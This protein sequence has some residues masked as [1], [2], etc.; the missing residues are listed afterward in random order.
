MRQDDAVQASALKLV[1]Y[2]THILASIGILKL[3]VR[4][5]LVYH[6]VMPVSTDDVADRLSLGPKSAAEL[7]SV[8]GASQS[9]ISRTVRALEREKRVLRIGGATR[10]ARYALRRS[11]GVSDSTWPIYRVDE[12]GA[13]QKIAALSA[14]HP[15]SIYATGQ[16]ERI[17]GFFPGI[18][19]YLQDARPAGFLG[20]AVPSMY[21]EL[22]LPARVADWTD[23]HFLTYLVERA[24]DSVGD[25]I[26]GATA[27]DRHLAG[28]QAPPVVS[29]KDR[30]RAYPKFAV[31]AM[32]GTPPGSS[33]QGEHPKFT[34]CRADGKR[35]VHVLVK[36]SP[37]RST[38]TGQRWADLL[39]AEHNAHRAL[40]EHGIAACRS[41]LLEAG[42]RVFLESERFDRID[43]RGRRGV[44]SLFAVDT[45]RYGQLDS[46][47]QCADRLAGDAMLS[48]EDAEGVR[49]LDAFGA[50]IANTDRHFGN[51][52]LFDH[53]QG[54]F[55]LAPVYDMLPMLFAPQDDQLTVKRF[56]PPV[57]RAAWLTVWDA[58]HSL[59]ESYWDGLAHD[60][61]ISAEFRKL[62]ARCVAALK[63]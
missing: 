63:R 46:W 28:A 7:M 39:T 16:L 29:I 62:S 52:T 34:V 40:E 4:H 23:D 51:I 42:D 10:G 43:E 19:Y 26:A 31:D 57:P 20:R 5:K 41:T 32:A 14:I 6:L 22:K 25:L 2:W 48:P 24:T 53:Y 11:V 58:A 56:E 38:A 27:L 60:A 35:R 15:S 33:A 36:F 59:A 49:F 21:P 61:A 45:D 1:T 3:L 8:L 30:K 44:V 13:V 55:G 18:P 9:T 37:P 47:T 50:L 12:R 17:Q 54:A